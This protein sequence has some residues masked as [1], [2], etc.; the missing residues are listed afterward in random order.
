MHYQKAGF[1]PTKDRGFTF[2]SRFNMGRQI[3]YGT[4][5][6]NDNRESLRKKAKV[7]L[8]PFTDNR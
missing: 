7:K 1:S 4:W 5:D 8:G 2:G 3:H 6:T